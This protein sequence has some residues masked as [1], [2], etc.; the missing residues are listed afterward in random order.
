MRSGMRFRG[1]LCQETVWVC[2]FKLAVDIVGDG[3]REFVYDVDGPRTFLKR[4]EVTFG[5]IGTSRSELTI[6]HMEQSS[7]IQ[8]H[9]SN[10]K[11]II[12]CT[13]E[14]IHQIGGF[15]VSKSGD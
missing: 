4:E 8:T 12:F 9:F 2:H 7:F 11:S 6:L 13:L 14:L 3:V 15:V 5:W 10:V 1:C